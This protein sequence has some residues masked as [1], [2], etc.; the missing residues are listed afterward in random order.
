MRW[1][2]RLPAHHQRAIERELANRFKSHNGRLDLGHEIA[3]LT[4]ED[5]DK[6]GD[7]GVGSWQVWRAYGQLGRDIN[8]ATLYS[9]RL[10]WIEKNL[11]DLEEREIWMRLFIAIEQERSELDAEESAER[12]RKQ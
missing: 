12:K 9:D 1:R 10:A 11:K 8:G 6:Y 5:K 2:G 4:G 7:L 3:D